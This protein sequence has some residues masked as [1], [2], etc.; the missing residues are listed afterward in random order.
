MALRPSI[1]HFDLQYGTS[2]LYMALRP[3]MWHFGP[4]YGTS[5]FYMALRP[6]IWHF[7][8][9]YGTSAFN[10]ALRPHPRT[11]LPPNDSLPA[12]LRQYNNVIN[13]Q[14]RQ[15]SKKTYSKDR[16]LYVNRTSNIPCHAVARFPPPI[17]KLRGP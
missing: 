16:A 8:L 3:S 12:A 11:T 2:A 14:Q 4:L 5:A 13:L 17:L 6:S 9:L 10:M 15:N 1:W 7:G